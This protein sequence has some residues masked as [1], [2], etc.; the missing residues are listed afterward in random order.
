M[1]PAAEPVG[2]ST[3]NGAL[4][5]NSHL[6]G[7]VQNARSE[8]R[9]KK[10]TTQQSVNGKGLSQTQI[11]NQNQLQLVPKKKNGKTIKLKTIKNLQNTYYPDSFAKIGSQTP[12]TNQQIKSSNFPQVSVKNRDS[13]PNIQPNE[14]FSSS[15]KV[16]RSE[17]KLTE[18]N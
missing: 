16:N 10:H 4:N 8:S 3:A 13:T 5:S 15:L 7:N 11:Q 18:A 14:R 12:S 9:L 17:H 6:F 1:K 2:S